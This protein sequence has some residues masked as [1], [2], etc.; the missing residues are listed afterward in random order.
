LHVFSVG[1]TLAETTNKGSEWEAAT[2]V[3]DGYSGRLTGGGRGMPYILK[4]I[5]ESAIG[6]AY[7]CSGNCTCIITPDGLVR[8]YLSA[9]SEYLPGV[10][11][12][13]V[14]P[15]AVIAEL[16]PKHATAA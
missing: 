11:L 15:L 9:G 5:T 14:I 3:A 7:V 12:C 2:A 1:A 6:T 8:E 4:T 13:A 16:K 10:H